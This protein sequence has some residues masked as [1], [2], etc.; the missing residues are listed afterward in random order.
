M[1]T[2]SILIMIT[3]QEFESIQSQEGYFVYPSP[4]PVQGYVKKLYVL[5]DNIVRGYYTIQEK[6]VD[7]QNETYSIM[8]TNNHFTQ[9]NK[10][11]KQVKFGGWRYYYPEE[12][13]ITKDPELYTKFNQCKEDFFE[14]VRLKATQK[15]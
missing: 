12:N 2:D 13:K 15:K 11:F 1:R 14:L 4:R 9:T 5:V 10:I 6:S 3:E 8:L 7:M